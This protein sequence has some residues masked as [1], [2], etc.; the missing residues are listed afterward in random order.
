MKKGNSV[1]FSTVAFELIVISRYYL[2]LCS[3]GVVAYFS[4]Y[5][6]GALTVRL[7]VLLA[8]RELA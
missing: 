4:E 5:L 8:S 6:V 7:Q 1:S 2:L 3:F